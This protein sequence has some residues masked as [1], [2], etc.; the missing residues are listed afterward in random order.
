VANYEG[1]RFDVANNKFHSFDGA[2]LG[3]SAW[4][5][6]DGVEPSAVIIGLHGMNDYGEAFYLAGPW[7]A[8]RGIA[9]FAYDARGFGRSPSRG[10]W[11]GERLMTEDVRTAVRVARRA[12]PNAKIAVVGDSMGA[13]TAIA[14][15]GAQGAP[16]IDRL[17]LV[18][19]AVWGWSTLPEHYAL[20]L[21]L[22][23]HTFPYRPVSP[24]RVV[25]RR[26]V[27]SDN[28]AMLRRI[29]RDRNMIFRTR[30][31]ALYGLVGLMERAS[32]R[33]GNLNGDVAFF[34]GAHDQIIPRASAVRAAR[35]LPA[36]ART[37]VYENGYHMLLRDLQ[38]EVVYADIL[39][40]LQ[41]ADAPF[42]SAAPALIGAQ[43]QS[44]N[45]TTQANR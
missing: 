43:N 28:T 24:P 11:G 30:I 44:A 40:F 1:P 12:Y 18:A 37:A 10:V 34:Y 36:S 15:F 42:P 4:L 20:T 3:L 16:E 13:A 31:D 8:E 19:P 23:A 2:E 21:W 33:S 27:A 14:T 5:P 39:A 35:R 22:G 6:A 45:A 9:T 26:I 25:T 38:A 7:F 29:G 17:V 41:D 32:Q